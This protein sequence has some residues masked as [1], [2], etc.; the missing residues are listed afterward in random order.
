MS[1]SAY[2]LDS[3]E[4]ASDSPDEQKGSM[5]RGPTGIRANGLTGQPAAVNEDPLCV[6][7]Q[8]A[9]IA[10]EIETIE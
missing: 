9:F 8:Q 10:T 2:H 5:V 3:A 4:V 6:Y 7:N 1:N